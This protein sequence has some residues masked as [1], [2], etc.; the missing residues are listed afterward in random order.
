MKTIV[1]K[2]NVLLFI[3][4]L[5]SFNN[6]SQEK[7]EVKKT[8]NELKIDVFDLAVFNALDFG[9]ENLFT[10]EMSYGISLFINFKPE[11][12][13]YEKLALTPFYRFYFFNNQEKG[14][15]GYYFEIF[16]KFASGKN[17]DI[18]YYNTNLNENYFDI[19]LGGAFG[20]KWVS[21]KGFILETYFGLGRNLGISNNSPD[22]AFRG[23]ISL[24]Y[25][26]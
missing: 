12:T 4:L 18:N 9:Y 5:M 25:R 10:E 20:R 26:F 11:E 17:L 16:S 8:K 21:H 3:I 19:N 24:G 1:K 6:F 14:S 7:Q 22:F 13:Y 23:G 15:N 2:Q